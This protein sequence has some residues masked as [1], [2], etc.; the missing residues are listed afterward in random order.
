MS[1]LNTQPRFQF[2]SG[3]FDPARVQLT[4]NWLRD[5]TRTFP[6]ILSRIPDRSVFGDPIRGI[7]FTDDWRQLGITDEPTEPAGAI[8]N[9]GQLVV[10]LNPRKTS[11]I[12]AREQTLAE[13]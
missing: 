9:N 1:M 2:S 6:D 7:T 11:Y 10:F 4:F 8:V 3:V 12:G 13:N 5:N